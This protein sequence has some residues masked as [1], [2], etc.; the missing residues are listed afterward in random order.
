MNNLTEEE[1]HRVT[2]QTFIRIIKEV[3]TGK[4]RSHNKILRID[5]ERSVGNEWN[6]EFESIELLKKELLV[7][8][9]VQYYNTDKTICVYCSHFFARGNYKSCIEYTDRNG[10]KQ[11]CNYSYTDSDKARCIRSIL[12]QYIFRKYSDKLSK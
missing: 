10:N 3:G 1:L 4:P 2:P 7:S 6:S 5:R 9:Y 11:T 12:L 8:L